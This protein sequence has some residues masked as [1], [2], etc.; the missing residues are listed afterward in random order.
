MMAERQ[1]EKARYDLMP[2]FYFDAVGTELGD[3]TAM[4]LVD[5][6]GDVRGMRILDLACGHGRITRELARRGARVTGIDISVALLGRALSAEA[7]EPLGIIYVKDTSRRIRRCRGE[8]RRGRLQPRTGRHRRSGRSPGHRFADPRTWRTV[9]AL[10]PAS[11]LPQVGRDRAEQLAARG[12]LPPVG[13]V[14]GPER[15][16]RGRGRCQ[17]PHALDLRQ[18]P[19]SLGEPGPVPGERVV[20]LLRTRG[21]SWRGRGF[22]TGRW[23]GPPPRWDP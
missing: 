23:V 14:A 15:G 4:T 19:H 7:Q 21:S 12:R 1:A 3:P 18:L 10:D 20:D 9:R 17:P 2:D 13:L 16:Y 5:L 11:L 22:A 6:L 8:V